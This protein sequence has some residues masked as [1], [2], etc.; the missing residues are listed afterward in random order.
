[1]FLD[2]IQGC[3]EALRMLRY[4]REKL[5]EVHVVAAGSL[6]EIVLAKA[7]I[8]FPVGRVQQMVM[9][10]LC[11]DEFLGAVGAAEARAAMRE[12]PLPEYAHGTLLDLFHR[13]ALIGGMPEVVAKYSGREE[14]TELQHIYESLLRSY[15]DDVPKYARNETMERVISHCIEAAPLAAGSR[16]TFSG[17][18][19]SNYRS[20]EVG[21]ALRILEKALLLH[22]L[23]PT[24]A[25]EIPIRPNKRKSPRLQF[26]DTG[27]LNYF[28][29]LQ[30]QHFSH[31]D[32]HSFYR[33]LLAEHVVGQELMSAR[34]SALHKPSF[35]VRE[36]RQSR[37]EVDFVI[38]HED[39]VVPV[40]VKAGKTGRL[41]SL[42][43]FMDLSPHRY[44]VRLY[45]GPLKRERCT[46]RRGT[47]FNLLSLPYFLAS[48][49]QDYLSWFIPS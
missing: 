10:P 19:Q 33:G 2:E 43:E 1:M 8:S 26:L 34:G 46:T 28:A 48:R 45:A 32:L 21:E 39:K 40:E 3:P 4:F 6:L 29:G 31:R 41:R 13:Y 24:T 38:H 30:K 27:L 16:I 37:A 44:A 5:S 9:Y 15:L 22:L 25:T 12:I 17:F 42:H 49:L 47:A 23:Y 20:R 35:W 14:V 18:G 7:K 36:K 11:F